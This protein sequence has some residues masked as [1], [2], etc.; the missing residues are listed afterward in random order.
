MA[1]EGDNAL[2]SLT[3]SIAQPAPSTTGLGTVHMA[4]SPF[5]TSCMPP[6]I[7]TSTRPPQTI[8]KSLAEPQRAF[9]SSHVY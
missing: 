4:R 5:S 3:K 2:G 7:T 9:W 8:A 6:E 1:S